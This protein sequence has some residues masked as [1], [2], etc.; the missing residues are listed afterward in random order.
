MLPLP[1]PAINPEIN[2]VLSYGPEGWNWH[3]ARRPY[4]N[5]WVALHG[6]GTMRIDGTDHPIAPAAAFFLNPEERIYA[7]HEP[8][9][10]VGNFSLHFVPLNADG[11]RWE[12]YDALRAAPPRSLQNWPRILHQWQLLRELHEI[13]DALCAQQIPVAA[14]LLIQMIWRDLQA[15]PEGPLEALIRTQAS[16]MLEHPARPWPVEELAREAGCTRAHYARCFAK[17]MR[18]PPNT[19]LIQLRTDAAANLLRDST[20]SIKQIADALGYADA[21]FF[22]RQFK[23]R[24]GV[25]PRTYRQQR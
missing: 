12:D 20:L 8:G 21:F 25:S 22:C 14:L 18:Q 5:L 11:S 2:C 15:P 13:Q 17:V 23:S 3:S 19:Y 1:F 10:P 6:R 4:V 16:R 24:M 9:E 7:F